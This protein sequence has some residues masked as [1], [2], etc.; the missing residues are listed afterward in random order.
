MVANENVY[1][2]ATGRIVVLCLVEFSAG[3]AGAGKETMKVAVSFS[4]SGKIG[5]G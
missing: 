3:L 5:K 4:Q 1:R 2:L